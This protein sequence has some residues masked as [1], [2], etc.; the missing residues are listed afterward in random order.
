MNNLADELREKPY[1]RCLRSAVYKTGGIYP[2]VQG[3]VCDAF[4][5]QV[6]RPISMEIWVRVMH[7]LNPEIANEIEEAE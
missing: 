3:S 6:R 2:Q 7:T 1:N 4:V 5:D